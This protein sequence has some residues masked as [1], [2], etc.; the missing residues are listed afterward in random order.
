M[1]SS[2]I[3][4]VGLTFEEAAS[5]SLDRIIK[6]GQQCTREDGTCAYSK[7]GMHCSVGWFLPD[8]FAFMG[9]VSRLLRGDLHTHD[10]PEETMDWLRKHE[11]E[12]TA[13]QSVH[14]YA[15]F[16][17]S[18]I[19]ATMDWSE[20]LKEKR[21]RWFNM[22]TGG[23]WLN[24]ESTR[25]A[26]VIQHAVQGRKE[27]ALAV[28]DKYLDEYSSCKCLKSINEFALHLT[29]YCVKFGSKLSRSFREAAADQIEKFRNNLDMFPDI[30]DSY[31]ASLVTTLK[32]PIVEIPDE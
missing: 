14:D 7:D 19:L 26:F 30:A 17:G 8:G 11:Q 18:A 20:I 27:E 2:M 22:I 16:P 1:A 25:A 3:E 24:H 15:N 5:L 9:T 21:D 10:I 4:V 32:Y 29:D 31:S 6:Q 12:L 13:L 28:L 23:D